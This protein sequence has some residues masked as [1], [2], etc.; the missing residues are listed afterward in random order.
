[1]ICSKEKLEELKNKAISQSSDPDDVEIFTI[2]LSGIE[3][4][5]DT[6]FVFRLPSSDELAFVLDMRE[7]LSKSGAMM[8][9][10][11]KKFVG[12]ILLFPD[13]PKFEKL[14]KKRPMIADTVYAEALKLAQGI[15][16]DRAKKL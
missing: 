4:D 16:S 5:G 9:S 11:T 8:L 13:V 2:R 14:C 3:S 15:E 6:D 10:E 12:G 1:M 7:K